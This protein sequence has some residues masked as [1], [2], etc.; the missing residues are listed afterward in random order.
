MKKVIKPSKSDPENSVDLFDADRENEFGEMFCVNPGIL[1][2]DADAYWTY[3]MNNP[4]KKAGRGKQT[5]KLEFTVCNGSGIIV[6]E[7]SVTELSEGMI[8]IEIKTGDEE[9]NCRITSSANTK[10]VKVK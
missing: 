10:V 8:A 6:I 3:Y 2:E 1:P 9:P 7:A 4:S 5:K